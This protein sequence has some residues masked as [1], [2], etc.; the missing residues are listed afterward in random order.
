[1]ASLLAQ[2]PGPINLR[3]VLSDLKFA[4]ILHDLVT[5]KGNRS[6]VPRALAVDRNEPRELAGTLHIEAPRVPV[7]SHSAN[8][9][10]AMTSN[11]A[12]SGVASAS[13]F[14]SSNFEWKAFDR[15]E[16]AAG[17]FPEG[18]TG[19]LQYQFPYARV[20]TQYTV[21][22]GIFGFTYSPKS[23]TFKGS[24]N[25][26]TWTTLDTQTNITD[27]A[28][29]RTIDLVNAVAYACYRLD[30]TASNNASNVG[31]GELEMMETVVSYGSGKDDAIAQI[32]AIN[33]LVTVGTTLTLQSTG[34]TYPV[35]L[36]ILPS[37]GVSQPL[38][39]L[40]E[41][42][43][44]PVLAS[45]AFSFTCEP[46]AYGPLVR[47]LDEIVTAPC[48]VDL[49][50][51]PGDYPAPLNLQ[52][53]T[54]STGFHAVYCGLQRPG[55]AD[56]IGNYLREAEGHAWTGGSTAISDK[57][58][59]H[60]GQVRYNNSTD[61]AVGD[62]F[63]DV[64]P[65]SYMLLARLYVDGVGN[66]GY[67]KAPI[68]GQFAYPNSDALDLYELGCAHLPAQRVLSGQA[69]RHTVMMASGIA[70]GGNVVVMD[71]EAFVPTSWGYFSWHPLT[72]TAVDPVPRDAF[73]V[74]LN[75]NAD[76]VYVGDI[77]NLA[78]FRG[79]P[80]SCVGPSHLVIFAE[81]RQQAP[82]CMLNMSVNVTPRYALWA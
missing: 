19:W 25:G 37:R 27:W 2:L 36:N 41:L 65:G 56:N 49:G 72:A 68:A 80:I 42:P 18:A 48:I 81:D 20:V 26:T 6:G 60:G 75:V 70:G 53:L 78:N 39:E 54:N 3:L 77:G 69:S 5:A 44:G 55:S 32:R 47:L 71:Y 28:V 13:S 12:P 22:P 52:F 79:G 58:T 74:K 62:G 40:F 9:I 24:N 59:A 45:C 11:T 73:A 35:T 51:V 38:D 7:Y 46:Y 61:Y 30:I 10:P 50:D 66:S 29:P 43:G 82:G 14:I 64:S 57:G 34:A 76:G 17:W 23:W 4:D 63:D 1:M 67:V 16:T 33:A 8:I 21:K 31:V 15:I